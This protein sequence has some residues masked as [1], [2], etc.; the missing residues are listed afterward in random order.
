[1]NA[2]E[3]TKIIHD[4]YSVEENKCIYCDYPDPCSGQ[5]E[6]CDHRYN[7]LAIQA[8]RFLENTVK[9]MQHVLS[10]QELDDIEYRLMEYPTHPDIPKLVET[11][12]AA[13][14]QIKILEKQV[15][16]LTGSDKLGKTLPTQTMGQSVPT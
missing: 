16:D 4:W 6:R 9:V 12:R 3:A 2:E 14:R 11:I 10:A 7:C 15:H 5:I 8:R 13:E 1:M